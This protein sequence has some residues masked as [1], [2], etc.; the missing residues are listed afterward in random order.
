VKL[1][2]DG[3]SVTFDLPGLRPVHQLRIRYSL[4]DPEGAAVRGELVVTLN[5]VR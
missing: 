1:S 3:R 2:G 4:R 5:G